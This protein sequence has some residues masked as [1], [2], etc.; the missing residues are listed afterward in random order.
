MYLQ[1]IQLIP[2]VV[3]EGGLCLVAY[4]RLQ[5]YYPANITHLAVV[6]NRE[7]RYNMTASLWKH[8]ENAIA[9]GVKH[10]FVGVFHSPGAGKGRTVLELLKQWEDSLPCLV[11]SVKEQIHVWSEEV[12]KWAPTIDVINVGGKST[13]KRLEGVKNTSGICVMNYE[14]FRPI[15]GACRDKKFKTV[16]LDEVWKVSTPKAKTTQAVLMYLSEAP[17]RIT[18]SPWPARRLL[19]HV[20]APIKFL[21]GGKRLGPTFSSFRYRFMYPHPAGFG[22]L[23]RQGSEEDVGKLIGDICSVVRDAD[24]RPSLGVPESVSQEILLD[25]DEDLKKVYDNILHEWA[26]GD[27]DI[28]G[29]GERY[30][31]MMQ[32][33]AGQRLGVFAPNSKTKYL[34]DFIKRLDERERVIVFTWFRPETEGVAETIRS[35]TDRLVVMAYGNMTESMESCMNRW[36]D[37]EGSVLVCQGGKTA[38]WHAH[39][40]RYCIFHSQPQTALQKYQAIRRLERPPQTRSV[41]V[42]DLIYDGTIEPFVAKALKEQK[43]FMDSLR[44]YVGT[45]KEQ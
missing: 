34:I 24:I 21:D 23:P 25:L 43:D 5:I 38:G 16:V 4:R 39:E 36:R 30:L 17:H 26:I 32:V 33:A 10:G 28:Q 8:Q 37:R 35:S 13:K 45:L 1:S 11:L 31:R 3:L 19:E 2:R 27:Y 9:C 29:G 22:W 20:Y 7:P 41:S 6:Q 44:D 12:K 14:S 42:T 15:R 40:S 18:L